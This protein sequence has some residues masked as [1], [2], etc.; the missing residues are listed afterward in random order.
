MPNELVPKPT[1]S[2]RQNEYTRRSRLESNREQSGEIQGSA[3]PGE[4]SRAEGN[5]IDES[6]RSAA[7][8]DQRRLYY[9]LSAKFNLSFAVKCSCQCEGFRLQE[10]SSAMTLPGG[11]FGAENPTG[12]SKNSGGRKLVGFLSDL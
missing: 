8:E 11:A 12:H 6:K 4:V 7:D 3:V 9:A 2:A 1:S 5:P 10:T